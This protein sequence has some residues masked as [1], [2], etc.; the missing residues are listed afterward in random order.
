V[1]L[2]EI[3]IPESVVYIGHGTFSSCSKLKFSGLPSHLEAL[4]PFALADIA[5]IISL[6]IPATLTQMGENVLGG[7]NF[8]YLENITVDPGNPLFTVKDGMLLTRDG[9]RLLFYASGLD[10][11][12]CVVP[13]GVAIIDDYAFAS[14]KYLKE[15]VLPDTVT[16]LGNIGYG[17]VFGQC[18]ALETIIIPPL[19]KSIDDA[20]FHNCTSLRSI[21]L[22]EGLE[23][24]GKMAFAGC[25]SLQY[26]DI[27]DS[28][29]LIDE[30]AFIHSGIKELRLPSMLSL[31]SPSL[32]YQCFNLESVIVPDGVEE[33]GSSSFGDCTALK[34]IELPDSVAVIGDNAFSNTAIKEFR[35]P[36]GVGAVKGSLFSGAGIEE[37]EAHPFVTEIDP[38]I[39]EEG[40]SPIIYGYKG[41]YAEQFSSDNGYTFVELELH[42]VTGI[43]FTKT[44]E[45]M[46]V[47]AKLGL[48]ANISPSDATYKK[49]TW[50]SS[51]PAVATVTA[52]GIVS[53]VRPG[54]AV[55]TATATDGSGVK[56]TC[57][58]TVVRLATSV[59]L[60]K[61]SATMGIGGTLGLTAAV[62]PADATNKQVTWSS[63]NTAVATVTSSGQVKA[64]KAGTAIIKATAADGS[65]KY[66]QCSVTVRQAGTSITLNKASTTLYTGKA[67]TLTASVYPAAAAG[68]VAW[69]SS[70]TAV[71]T[72]TSS[73]QVKGI[74]AGTAVI[75]ATVKDGSTK[76]AQCKVTVRQAVTGIKLN[77][78]S[79]TLYTGKTE[80]L[81]ASI[82]PSGAY[83]KQVTWSS[84]NTA[85]ATV[86]SSG[87][88]KGIK[89]GT[90]VI[91]A[92]AKDGSTKYAQCKVTVRQAVTGIKLNKSNMALM[93]G[94][95]EKLKLS[96]LPANASNKQVT[97]TSSNT[98][99][100]TV[101]SSGQ[102]M[103]IKAGTAVIKA[104]AKDGSGKYAQCKVTVK[105]AAAEVKLSKASAV[106]TVG[107]TETLSVLVLPANASNKQVIWTSSNA[108]V[109]TV[110][111]SGVVK[112]I[113]VGT[114][115]IKAT[116]K[117]GST[118][119]GQCL[120][121]V[122]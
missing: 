6:H 122:K 17:E 60:N 8:R 81:K 120:V 59:T 54:T 70:N 113:K 56:E 23:K 82:A 50:T 24:L 28:V 86:T 20:S 35:V 13:E 36:L 42:L 109:A 25:S 32:F 106:L 96:V 34:V 26:I 71:A 47:G 29:S 97:W 78:T 51:D 79:T 100:A 7:S 30:Y 66:G 63:S 102:V 62:S 9:T 45:T 4:G 21:Q 104:T 41:T 93:A 33:L 85:V 94:K 115:V 48:T 119:Y 89:A 110:N 15:V 103:A 108:A 3:N 19:V 84:S 75:T 44:S 31:V 40:A 1:N 67:E 55:I 88:V 73:G 77:K 68:K 116:A 22:P 18:S 72:V 80:T 27:P 101:S 83:N 61:S 118:K 107:K 49:V 92:T 12:S 39:F 10:D 105:Q 53:A 114:A 65:G 43:S 90:A 91:K 2:V 58:L 52:K 87:Q 16:K 117:D 37:L 98:A 76:Y 5:S 95:T 74:K 57:A 38:A 46:V 112:G 111:S 11:V 69:T 14:A 99:V 64:I 121:T